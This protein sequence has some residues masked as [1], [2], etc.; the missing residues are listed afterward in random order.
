MRLERIG[1]DNCAGHLADGEAFLLSHSD[2]V[3]PV[4]RLTVA[5]FDEVRTN[6]EVQ[7]VDIRNAGELEVNGKVPGTRHIPLAELVKRSDE[8]DP[9]R[10]VVLHC[11]GGWRSSVGASTLRAHG[12]TDVS[13]LLG[14]FGAWSAAHP[15][16][17]QS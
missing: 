11:A 9:T 16:V 12:F 6:P 4:S 2:R 7:V 5:Q 17:Q 8:L 10:P 13:D 1:Y 14:G 3:S 15:D